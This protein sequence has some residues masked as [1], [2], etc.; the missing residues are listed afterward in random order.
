[1]CVHSVVQ[2]DAPIIC[3]TEWSVLP[4]D[5]LCDLKKVDFGPQSG[6]KGFAPVLNVLE[7]IWCLGI[8]H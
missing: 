7:D 4:V 8:N 5:N 3:W 6:V 1:M 2:L